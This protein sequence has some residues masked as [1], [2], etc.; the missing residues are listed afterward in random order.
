MG[1]KI[2]FHFDVNRTIIATDN[3]NNKDIKDG[4]LDSLADEVFLNLEDIKKISKDMASDK[5]LAAINIEKIIRN[6]LYEQ[7]SFKKYT[8]LVY[9]SDD[10]ESKRKKLDWNRKELLK[11]ASENQIVKFYNAEKKAEN[12]VLVP[13]FINF[14]LFLKTIKESFLLHFRTFGSD[15]DNIIPEIKKYI[16]IDFY[17]IRAQDYT[18][19]SLAQILLEKNCAVQ[20]DYFQWYNADKD[21]QF[22]KLFPIVQNFQSTNISDKVMCLF[23]DDNIPKNIVCPIS[24]PSFSLIH[25]STHFNK[26]LFPVSIISALNDDNYFIDIFQRA[27]LLHNYLN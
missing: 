14:L 11:F 22:G 15:I 25:P 19:E 5:K 8:E 24:Y 18:K 2:I 12:S 21:W 17:K 16:D 26:S 27:F 9:P 1:Y 6:E 7:I 20:D 4:L 10:K 13:A 3:N 23:F